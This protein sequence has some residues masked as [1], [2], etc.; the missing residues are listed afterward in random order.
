MA[1]KVKGKADKHLLTPQDHTRCDSHKNINEVIVIHNTSSSS[2][3]E[4]RERDVALIYIYNFI[5]PSQH[6]SIADK[7]KTNK[8]K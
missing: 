5:S 3:D 1:P 2:G 8:Y 7:N 4:I 6:G